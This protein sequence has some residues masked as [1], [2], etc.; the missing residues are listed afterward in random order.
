MEHSDFEP[1]TAPLQPPIEKSLAELENA[2]FEFVRDIFINNTYDGTSC[3]PSG[4]HYKK[5]LE[6]GSC[7]FCQDKRE[8]M[9]RIHW[10]YFWFVSRLPSEIRKTFSPHFEVWWYNT[11]RNLMVKVKRMYYSFP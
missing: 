9:T 4:H 10:K 1:S 3:C 2:Y 8:Q 6:S 5:S 11:G 7:V